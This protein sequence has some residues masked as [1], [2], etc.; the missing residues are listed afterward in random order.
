[1]SQTALDML[2]TVKLTRDQWNIAMERCRDGHD[3]CKNCVVALAIADATFIDVDVA[4]LSMSTEG[5]VFD[6]VV[7]WDDPETEGALSEFDLGKDAVRLAN[8]FDDAIKDEC[9]DRWPFPTDEV[10][11]R[12]VV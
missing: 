3:V 5:H 7:M 12:L 9:T 11:L 8:Q 2:E 4:P 10:E 6:W 1:M